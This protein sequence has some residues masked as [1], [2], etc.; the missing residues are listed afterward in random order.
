MAFPQSIQVGN[1]L[2]NVAAA[3]P[4]ANTVPA[5]SFFCAVDVTALYQCELDAAGARY[6]LALVGGTSSAWG[7]YVVWPSPPAGTTGTYPTWTL[8]QAAAVADG[9]GGANVATLLG[10]P[11]SVT[12]NLAMRPGIMLASIGGAGG[13]RER[14]DVTIVGQHTVA[15]VAGELSITGISLLSTTG[16]PLT[17]GGASL[18]NVKIAR[19][20]VHTSNVGSR[21]ILA[22]NSNAGGSLKIEESYV[23]R[24][25]GAPATIESA[26]M[27]V[28]GVRSSIIGPVGELNLLLAVGANDDLSSCDLAGSIQ[29]ESG[30]C[31]LYRSRVSCTLIPVCLGS[32]TYVPTDIQAPTGFS[33]AATATVTARRVWRQQSRTALAG[34]GPFALDSTIADT[35]AF[36]PG[37]NVVAAATLPDVTLFDEGTELTLLVSG[38]ALGAAVVGVV[39]FAGQTIDGSP[40]AFRIYENG[41]VT[42]RA[43][44]T[45]AN[46]YT[47]VNI[48]GKPVTV[49][50][51]ADAAGSDVNPG[52]AALPIRTVLRGI[53]LVAPWS[54]SATMTLAD[55]YTDATLTGSI[56]FPSAR[57]GTAG[58]SFA[59]Q[60]T[61]VDDAAFGITT[62]TA[63]TAQTTD[64]YAP[65]SATH[66]NAALAA[67]AGRGLFARWIT[68]TLAGQTK[69]LGLTSNV[70]VEMQGFATNPGAGTFAVQ[71]PGASIG[72]PGGFAVT[73]SR[74]Q[75]TR[76]RFAGVAQ[77]DNS[78]VTFSSCECANG[79]TLTSSGTV[80]L[81][82]TTV[83]VSLGANSG[84][85]LTLGTCVVDD[86]S[87]DFGTQMTVDESAVGLVAGP[88]VSRSTIALTNSI[89]NLDMA[90][91]AN[92]TASLSQ[93]V[94]R[95]AFDG[96]TLTH[97]ST[98]RLLRFSGT[99][100][101]IGVVIAAGQACH[102]S[103]QDPTTGT[104]G[105]CVTGPSGDTQNGSLGVKTWTLINGG[106][107]ANVFESTGT[108][109]SGS[110]IT[111]QT[112]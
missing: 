23:D 65:A 74:V 81:S 57:M 112:F 95:G 86:L 44:R 56:I 34:A 96:L 61:L 80:V 79:V 107:A 78:L 58:T 104:T 14:P 76:I 49:A 31:I 105:T 110:S 17:I 20:Y 62:T 13:E 52:T 87:I 35:T 60:G 26:A 73:N 46:W 109:A 82:V 42:L 18:I 6:W 94:S 98:A 4:A 47:V 37:A 101:D 40:N 29:K 5:G 24:S 8:A 106:L 21:A 3:I 39:P 53:A 83:R 19:S 33:I 12:E 72:A 38:S 32:A 75:F 64:P 102:V 77:A 2:Y 36:V 84:G 10:M 55:G 63:G 59:I 16:V 111:K 68:G 9:F 93:C 22:S 28:Q 48:T 71:R 88:Q 30:T 7:K 51:F 90:V 66:A 1:I 89:V 15:D 43:D 108:R 67:N 50:V 103:A 92:A 91:T 41:R 97:R 100:T 27:N 54:S 25:T 70:L 85:V 45:G 69:K 99:T 11:G